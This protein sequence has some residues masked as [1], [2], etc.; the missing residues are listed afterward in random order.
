M[1]EL[2]AFQFEEGKEVRTLERDGEPWFVATDV[3]EL[4]ELGNSRDALRNLDDDEKTTL[5]GGEFTLK[6]A[7]QNQCGGGSNVGNTDI[8]DKKIPNRG[9][10]IINEPGLYRLIFSSRKSEAKA[11]KKWVFTEVLPAIRKQ[12]YY[13][14]Q[15]KDAEI[16]DL[17]KEVRVLELK[18]GNQSPKM[19][20]SREA[21]VYIAKNFCSAKKSEY[22]AVSWEYKS[23]CKECELTV[24][25]SDF[26]AM[27][28]G[29]FPE[30]KIKKIGNSGHSIFGI[31]RFW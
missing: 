6:F 8:R 10:N 29:Y 23:Y 22:I 24:S 25:E 20:A 3:C 15:A 18:T 12:G 27:L 2:T 4:L 13:I 9:L 16:A 17:R 14:L 28:L 30:A 11:F 26:I 1:N 5:T 19:A 7:G 21:E 31:K